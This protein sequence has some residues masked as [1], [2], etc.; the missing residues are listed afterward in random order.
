MK[1]KNVIKN[2]VEKTANYAMKWYEFLENNKQLT[3]NWCWNRQREKLAK[4]GWNEKK[5]NEQQQQN[6]TENTSFSSW[7][8]KIVCFV[9]F[10][11]AFKR[12]IPRQL[13]TSQLK[14]RGKTKIRAIALMQTFWSLCT[15]GNTKRSST[16]QRQML[17]EKPE[18]GQTFHK[19]STHDCANV[20]L[21]T[22]DDFFLSFFFFS[23]SSSSMRFDP[24]RPQ[25]K[26]IQQCFSFDSFISFDSIRV[27]FNSFDG[28]FFFVRS[29]ALAFHVY[30]CHTACFFIAFFL[31]WFSVSAE[32]RQSRNRR[33]ARERRWAPIDG[34]S[35]V[36]QK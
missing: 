24:T 23:V 18:H 27:W 14:T 30:G 21:Y 33:S 26:T 3:V 29:Y 31:L 35:R 9:S 7:A 17:N 11:F 28:V 4:H 13:N 5:R 8:C 19:R 6:S 36:R 25:K 22:L 10:W 34:W 20:Q 1:K 2:C 12:K 15:N 32:H 16:E